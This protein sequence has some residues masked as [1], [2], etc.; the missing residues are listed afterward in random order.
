[1]QVKTDLRPMFSYSLFP[2]IFLTLIL[3]IIFIL[4]KP[5]KKEE[6]E[7]IQVILPPKN[8]I[9]EIK[10]RY[11]IN[12]DNLTNSFVTKKI[13]N[14]KAYQTLSSLIRNFIYETTNIKVQNYT[15]S[16]IQK[17]NIPVLYELVKEYYAPEFSEK[18]KGNIIVSIEKTRKVIEKW[19]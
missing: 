2:I 7:Q 11:L 10:K 13:N 17:V 18:S 12:L 19:N 14:R 8:D 5:K 1:M 9:T 15:L 6:K 16:E 3:V 4:I